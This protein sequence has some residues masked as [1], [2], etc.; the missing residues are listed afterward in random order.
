M[1]SYFRP[2]RKCNVRPLPI[3]RNKRTQRGAQRPAGH[4]LTPSG[5]R[6]PLFH[7]LLFSFTVIKSVPWERPHNHGCLNTTAYPPSRR[8]SPLLK[9]EATSSGLFHF[10]RKNPYV[11]RRR[12]LDGQEH[13]RPTNG[14][15]QTQ[16][17][18]GGEF[19]VSFVVRL[20]QTGCFS[21]FCVP[22]INLLLKEFW[23]RWSFRVQ[24]YLVP[25]TKLD[26]IFPLGIWLGGGSIANAALI[27][28]SVVHL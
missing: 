28:C 9:S 5:S 18:M 19:P 8:Y 2:L 25:Y 22:R 17:P 23:V 20:F 24:Q 12:T 13:R 3:G 16:V 14:S 10:E 26:D 27:S 1:T 11:Q 7:S 15:R 6:P 4:R 21:I